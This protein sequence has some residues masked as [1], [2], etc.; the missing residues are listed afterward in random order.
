M[1]VTLTPAAA[2]VR[3]G[4]AIIVNGAGM[5]TQASLSTNLAGANNDLTYTAVTPGTGGNSVTV[6]YAVAGNNTALSVGVVGSDITVN[7]ATDGGGAATSTAAL[8]LAAVQAS[9]A[10]SALVSVALKAANDGTGVAIALVKTNLAG[11]LSPNVELEFIHESNPTADVRYTEAL[12]ATGTVAN[13]A[14]D[15]TF[16]AEMPGKVKVR[17]RIAGVVVASCEVI[18]Q[19]S[20]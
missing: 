11:G 16:K 12:S 10:A 13:S 1:A 4:D 15:L 2:H 6:T 18:V 8:I 7:L 17:A 19:Q 5:G 3:V 14:T 20:S 9:V